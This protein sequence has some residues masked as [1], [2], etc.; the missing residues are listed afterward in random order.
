M[1]KEP[2]ILAIDQGTT[3]SRA[4]VFDTQGRAVSHAQMEFPQIYPRDGWV[5]HDPEAIWSTTL[6]VSRQAFAQA[7]ARGGRVVAIGIT[8]QRETA[9]VW[10]RETGK[11]VCNAIVW[12]DRRTADACR[13]LER[14]NLS[15]LVQQRTGL[16]LDPYFS[17]S[18]IAWILDNVDG[19]RARARDGR[20]AFGTIDAFLI[21]RLT[22]HKVH[23]TD[24]TN[25]S[26]TCLFN[27]HRQAWDAELLKLFDIPEAI[28]PLVKDCADDFGD[29]LP[30]LF[31]RA[32][33]IAG[34][35][36]DQQAAAFGQCCFTP[37]AIKSTYGTGCFM[38]MNIGPEPIL[39]GN[40]LLTTV[41][42]RLHGRPTYALEGS[43]FI[44]GAAV[45]WLRDGIGIIEHAKQTEA[46]VG[47]T[48]SN[49]GVYLVPAF[50]GLGAPWWDPD[51]RGA[52]FGIN[53]ATGPAHFVR[54]ALESVCY[55]TWDLFH[56]M[57]EDGVSPSRLRVDGGMVANNWFVQFLAD[58]LNLP[59]DR[60]QLLETTALGAAYLAGM[61]A[62]VM[63]GMDEIAGTWRLEQRF[64]PR[65]E[66]T[67]RRQHLAGWHDAVRRTL[68][69]SSRKQPA[70]T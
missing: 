48:E 32:I 27:I 67:A 30:E 39:S 14:E 31:G 17:A 11:P 22:G 42:C 24:A 38:L 23:A 13:R 70:A 59:V 49:D 33:P 2:Y 45:Q 41:A 34:V 36:G 66:E 60:P 3:S 12:Q 7:E 37:G 61:Q 5:E 6:Q 1:T 69:A 8:N 15:A 40:H 54:A 46:L 19:A 51:A 55:Q 4:I 29:T 65:M 63:G 9:V 52:I 47:Q 21:A 68:S 57:A 18:K 53:R 50:T 44:A 10:D 20:L 43:I 56:A 16:L 62:G 26:R 35:A 58:I 64:S 25:A 28:M